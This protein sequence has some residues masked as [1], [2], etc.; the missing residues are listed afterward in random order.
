MIRGLYQTSGDLGVLHAIKVFPDKTGWM[1]CSLRIQPQILA[2]V[3]IP[4][5]RGSSYKSRVCKSV[6][7]WVGQVE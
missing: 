7:M 3:T 2:V 5:W 6:G 1:R 4:L